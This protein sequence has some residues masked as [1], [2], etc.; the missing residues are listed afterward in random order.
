MM[1]V[2]QPLLAALAL[3]LLRPARALRPSH[4]LLDSPEA[5]DFRAQTGRAFAQLMPSLVAASPSDDA[6]TK[7]AD[8]AAGDALL[9]KMNRG[10]Q[11]VEDMA[12]AS[13]RRGYVRRVF[14]D[15]AFQ[16][17]ELFAAARRRGSFAFAPGL[18][19]KGLPSERVL[20]GVLHLLY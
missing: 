12:D 9:R 4:P 19:Q 15:R 16:I 8:L 20:R 18:A 17:C 10:E 2:S 7:G 13:A 6:A 11:T 5:V 1:S 3:L 14:N